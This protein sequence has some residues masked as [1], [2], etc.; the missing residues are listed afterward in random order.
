MSN[1]TKYLSVIIDRMDQ[2]WTDIPHILSGNGRL[3][4]LLRMFSKEIN[5][6][7]NWLKTHATNLYL[8]DIVQVQELLQ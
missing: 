2:D 5:L 7:A 1:Q 4:G 6:D 3:M 8:V